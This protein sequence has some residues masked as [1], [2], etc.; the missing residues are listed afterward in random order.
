M[1]CNE[2]HSNCYEKQ[3]L[4]SETISTFIRLGNNWKYVGCRCDLCRKIFCIGQIKKL[5]SF[6]KT[7]HN[8]DR[9]Q[10]WCCLQLW[11][12]TPFPC[13]TWASSLTGPGSPTPLIA[14]RSSS[15]PHSHSQNILKIGWLA[16]YWTRQLNMMRPSLIL[17]L[18]EPRAWEST[19]TVTCQN[20][21][22]FP[23]FFKTFFAAFFGSNFARFVVLF[24]AFFD[25]SS[26]MKGFNIL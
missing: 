24:F 6:S 12:P 22:Q 11:T 7:Y 14:E 5:R 2:K 8:S 16:A 1:L 19:S 17:Q 25:F 9:T 23:D 4:H 20:C 21:Y 3:K 18:I 15:Y 26:D 10:G 13:S